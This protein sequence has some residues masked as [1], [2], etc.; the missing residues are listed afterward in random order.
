[1][2]IQG[3]VQGIIPGAG[4]SFP[5]AGVRAKVRKHLFATAST[6]WVCP[7]NVYDVILA[8]CG[9]GGGGQGTF[10]DSGV[11][12]LSYAGGGGAAVPPQLVRVVPGQAYTITV[13]AGGS[14]G[15]SNNPWP[16]VGGTSV[17]TGPLVYIRAQGGG[18]ATYSNGSGGQTFSGSSSQESTA[19]PVPGEG[20]GLVIVGGANGGQAL[21]HVPAGATASVWGVT[22][23]G[24]GASLFSA[25]GNAGTTQSTPGFGAGGGAVSNTGQGQFNGSPGGPG[26]VYLSWEE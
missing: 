15:Y 12:V 9:G 20:R 4:Q 13:G 3:A 7:P 19:Y 1:M 17:F 10:V 23:N 5:V 11:D 16:G 24:G 6:T 21:Q 8:M 14:G 22:I 2:S 25:G 26:F 18:G